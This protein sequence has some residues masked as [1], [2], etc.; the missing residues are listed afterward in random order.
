[1][2]ERCTRR[3]S[4]KQ[5]RTLWSEHVQQPMVRTSQIDTTAVNV[6]HQADTLQV[7]LLGGILSYTR[8]R[9]L[10]KLQFA[11]FCSVFYCLP[12]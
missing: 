5:R 8:G 6:P 9:K 1:M 10:K 7:L 4:V 11:K 3:P 2:Y 12:L